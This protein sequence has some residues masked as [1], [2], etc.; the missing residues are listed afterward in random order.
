MQ[1]TLLAAVALLL[2]LGIGFLVFTQML[3]GEPSADRRRADA[4]VVLTGGAERVGEGL[5]LLAAGEG[6]RLLI[7]GVHP[8]TTLAS[9]L[10]L[11]PEVP[12]SVAGQITLDR[13]ASD[14]LGNARETAAWVRDGKIESLRVVTAAYHMPRSLLELRRALPGVELIAHPVFPASLSD[15]KWWT[16]SHTASLLLQEYLKYLV[17]LVSGSESSEETRSTS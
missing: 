6:D 13:E 5:R 10:A 15:A 12:E 11:A 4:I 7:S 9:L 3:P 14:T 1:R 8:E 17:A 2:A 16:S